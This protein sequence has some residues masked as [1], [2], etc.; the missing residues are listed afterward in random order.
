M[1][2]VVCR[3][4][5][6][7]SRIAVGSWAAIAGIFSA[8]ASPWSLAGGADAVGAAAT[9]SPTLADA[10]ADAAATAPAKRRPRIGLV[11]GGGGAKGAAHVGVLRVL[12]EMHVPID[13]VAGTSM[14]ALVGGTFAA[15]SNAVELET[16]IHQISWKDTIAFQ[17]AR[18]EEPMRRKNAGVIYSNQLEFGIRD[19]A[20]TPPAGLINA[21][22][23]DQTI[24]YLVARS[25]GVTD[26]D[27]LPIPFRAVATDMQKGEMVVLSQGD[28]GR[29]MRASMSVPGVFAPVSLDGRLLGDGGL[30]RNLPVDVARQTCADVVI[31]VAVP[32][33][34]PTLEDMQ[35]PLTMAA[36][37]L[38][39]LIGANERAQIQTLGPADVMITVPMGEIGSASFDKVDEAI[40]LGR[41]AALEHRAELA[42]YSVPEPEY[43]AWRE[44]VSRPKAPPVRLAAIRIE[45]LERVNPDYVRETL[46]LQPGDEVTARTIA[47]RISRVY[48]LGD[49]ET[50]QYSLDG[51]PAEPTLV[52]QVNEKATGPNVL[53]FDLGLYMGT[54]SNT[55]FALGADYRRTWINAQGGEFHGA[56]VIGRTSAVNLSVYQPLDVAHRWFVEPGTTAQS[57][58]QDIYVEGNSVAAYQFNKAY[59]FLDAGRVFGT[60]AE[61]RAGLRAGGQSVTREIALP[62]LDEIDWEGYGG[63]SLRYTYDD[64]DTAGMPHSGLLA[65]A[66]YFESQGWL[67]A[68][69][70]YKRTEGLLSYALPVGSSVAYLRA[71][72]GASLNT[73]LP[74]YDAFMLGGP[75]SFPGFGIGELR[76]E[77]YWVASA[78][79]LKKIAQIS[80]LFGQ[81]LYLGAS[82]TAGDMN[83]QFDY[84]GAGPMYSGAVLIGG[85]TPLGPL[86]LSLAVTSESDWQ[87]VFSLG[88]PII[89]HT[90]MDPVW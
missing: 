48:A 70:D 18:V 42:R 28:L 32:N 77:G 80:D 59:G 61:L 58:I 44:S 89:E 14:G 50:V 72:G 30:T 36:V 4:G 23:I 17:G 24:E 67:G 53:R 19:G 29:A 40:P 22:R 12:D 7:R 82:V 81:A 15:G 84:P 90:I 34:A 13:C 3:G 5:T 74:E 83:G 51:A 11:L 41:A 2:R 68:A 79:Y 86:T 65:R 27:Q 76:G 20:I 33:P 73:S 54:D 66:E 69:R 43:L 9:A 16:S 45:G 1:R 60:R 35:S 25:R 62:T 57:A 8:L 71:A 46:R 38:D 64:R 52:V 63:F 88:R 56:A 37:T 78:T 49:F 87:A 21:Q 47:D 75:L 31:A 39:I 26:F 6:V 55:A 10:S 85:R